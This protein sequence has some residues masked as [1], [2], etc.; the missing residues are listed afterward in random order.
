MTDCSSQDLARCPCGS[1]LAYEQC[2]Q[3]L[4]RGE[5]AATPEALMRSRYSAFVVGQADYLLATW[6]PSTRP[7][8]LSLEWS[9]DWVS[10]TILDSSEAGEAGQVHFRAVHRVGDGWGYLEEQSQFVREQGRWLYVTG[11]TSEGQLKPG[12]NDRC[13]CGSGRKYKA[14][15]L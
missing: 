15:C 8:E 7:V 5:A 4:H 6:H 3:P 14:C 11:D 9:P 13:P 12:R 10:L 1:T 2:C